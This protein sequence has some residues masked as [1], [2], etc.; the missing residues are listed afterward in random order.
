MFP[1]IRKANKHERSNGY[2]KWVVVAKHSDNKSYDLCTTF[3]DAFQ[4]WLWHCGVPARMAFFMYKRNTEDDEFCV[5]CSNCTYWDDDF[6]CL[7]KLH[8]ID[9]IRN[10]VCDEYDENSDKTYVECMKGI[11]VKSKTNDK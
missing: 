1:Y 4:T 3:L 7:K 9:P 5:E 2:T 8:I 10:E 6:V 11:Y